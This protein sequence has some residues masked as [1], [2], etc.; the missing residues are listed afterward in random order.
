MVQFTVIFANI[1]FLSVLDL[2]TITQPDYIIISFQQKHATQY[3]DSCAAYI[4][5]YAT[6]F[7]TCHLPNNCACYYTTNNT[8]C[9]AMNSS[10][11]RNDA[12]NK[13]SRSPSVKLARDRNSHRMEDALNT[14]MKDCIAY[15]GTH[16]ASSPRAPLARSQSRMLL[17]IR[18][19][20]Q[21]VLGLTTDRY[22]CVDNADCYGT[23]HDQYM[24][25]MEA[26]NNRS[27]TRPFG[28]FKS[29]VN[30][31]SQVSFHT[32]IPQSVP[33]DHVGIYPSYTPSYGTVSA[34]LLAF[35]AINHVHCITHMPSVFLWFVLLSHQM[36]V[37]AQA[38]T[39]N[40]S[41]FSC[42]GYQECLDIQ[43]NDDQDCFVA[44]AGDYACNTANIHAPSNANLFVECS[45][46]R[47]CYTATIYGPSIGNLTVNCTIG[48]Y[49]CYDVTIHGPT[50]GTLTV[51]CEGAGDNGRLC[52]GIDIYCPI[53]GGCDVQCLEG[54]EYDCLR[55]LLDARSMINGALSLYSASGINK[56]TVWC[57]PNSGN[58]N[59]CII[60]CESSGSGGCQSATIYTKPDT[61]LFITAVGTNAL[62]SMTVYCPSGKGTCSIKASGDNY[63]MLSDLGIY[64]VNG[65][66]DVALSCNA[67]DSSYCYSVLDPVTIACSSDYGVRGYIA[68]Q[69][70]S[71]DDWHGADANLTSLCNDDTTNG[72]YGSSFLCSEHSECSS[73]IFC[74]DDQDC[75]VVCDGTYSC[76]TGKIYA[77]S[78]ANLVVE[79]SAA[80]SCF[81]ATIYGPSI[82]N[83]VVNCT[84]ALGYECYQS[85]IHGPTNGNLTVSLDGSGFERYIDIDCPLHG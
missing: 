54:D 49:T 35:F 24:T 69:S 11:F 85:N 55:L 12:K 42:T 61:K 18:H 10:E 64:S 63:D 33:F 34:S 50:N 29:R 53:Y 25:R 21:M 48:R 84:T 43:C 45:S 77:P 13:H 14:K 3:V 47:S 52:E 57:P 40:G 66:N 62:K 20:N 26:S 75:S 22:R 31:T 71:I 39:M 65:L 6:S 60:S 83:M 56:G 17:P 81:Y 1:L 59:E 46:T 5:D 8:E 36:I 27:L 23:Q 15:Y 7:I 74:N 51:I 79:C 19:A 67:S 9:I 70:G 4:N 44:C 38:Q 80:G 37:P 78:N 72:Y 82:G 68:L 76:Q 28:H 58:D 16:V 73:N 30:S 2:Y 32:P 41:S